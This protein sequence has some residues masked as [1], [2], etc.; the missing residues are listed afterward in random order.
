MAL[1]LDEMDQL[2]KAAELYRESRSGLA[3]AVGLYEEAY[4][5]LSVGLVCTLMRT[6]KH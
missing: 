2:S 6:G 4:I 1:C 5:A 3:G